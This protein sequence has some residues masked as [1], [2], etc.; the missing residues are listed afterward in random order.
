LYRAYL[1]QSHIFIGIYWQSYGWVAS[2]MAISGLE[3]EYLLSE[4][5]PR[6]I[7]IK[8]PA[9]D[10]EQGLMEM[11]NR[12]KNEGNVS[13]KYFSTPQE[14]GELIADDLVLMLSERFEISLIEKH[15]SDH[16]VVNLQT[17]L[18]HELSLFIGREKQIAEL[19]GL[20]EAEDTRLITLTGPGGVGK[21]RL[22][23]KV[24]S[25]L[26]GYFKDG[27]WLVELA[28]LSDRTSSE[29]LQTKPVRL[30]ICTGSFRLE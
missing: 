6:L 18:P 11:L 19:S 28:S 24:A 12:I 1:S 29:D 9:P 30:S 27:V 4:N 5:M 3:D 8:N 15:L 20:L 25:N 13:F 7:Y 21:T 10:R 17:N 16:Q 26:L 14:L 23:I 22:A 2:D